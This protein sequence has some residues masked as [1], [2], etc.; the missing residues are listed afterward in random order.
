[1]ATQIFRR[2]RQGH[3]GFYYCRVLIPSDLSAILN[4]RAFVRCLHTA[5]YSAATLKALRWNGELASL[6]L[7]LRRTHPSLKAEQ[8][9]ALVHEYVAKALQDGEDE[10]HE[11][12]LHD[13]ERDSIVDA[14]GDMLE[15]TH[16]TLLDA[17]QSLRRDS[18]G[19]VWLMN[20]IREIAD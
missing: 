19:H 15:E 6:F 5:E 4:R 11:R 20:G 10:Q 14:L 12:T 7:R 16:A 9:K 3:K 13:D 2:V 1:M 18:K 8:I 17:P